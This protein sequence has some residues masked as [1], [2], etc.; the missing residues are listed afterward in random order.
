MILYINFKRNRCSHCLMLNDRIF[1]GY[2][3]EDLEKVVM[4]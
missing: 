4:L 3:K 1:K 2:I